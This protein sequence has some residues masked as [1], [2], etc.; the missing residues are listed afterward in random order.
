M[1]T[2]SS[3]YTAFNVTTLWLTSMW[4][5]YTDDHRL[6]ILD[7]LLSLINNVSR[8]LLLLMLSHSGILTNLG[9]GSTARIHVL[10][11]SSVLDALP[12]TSEP[13]T[14][15]RMIAENPMQA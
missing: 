1:P 11:I 3:I 5:E 10:I 7:S 12:S 14:C 4:K 6:K 2:I 8:L 13:L 9:K 15:G